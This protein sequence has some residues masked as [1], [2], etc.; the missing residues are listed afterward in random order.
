[1][2][3]LKK[4][5]DEKADDDDVIKNEDDWASDFGDKGLNW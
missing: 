5:Y 1:M 3:E 4:K 2:E